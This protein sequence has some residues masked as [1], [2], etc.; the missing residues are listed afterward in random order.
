MGTV[1][2]GAVSTVIAAVVLIAGGFQPDL[3]GQQ[4]RLL[5]AGG[6]AAA[7]TLLAAAQMTV[8]YLSDRQA[9]K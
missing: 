5:V 1:A 4:I 8:A 2:I 9:K 3:K 7:S 6:F